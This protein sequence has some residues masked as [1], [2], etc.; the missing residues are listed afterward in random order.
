MLAYAVRVYCTF[1][2]C[3]PKV[4]VKF[5]RAKPL[6][7]SGGDDLADSSTISHAS[8][9]G[10]SYSITNTL[11]VRWVLYRKCLRATAGTKLY[12][13]KDRQ[14]NAGFSP[15]VSYRSSIFRTIL[16]WHIS[17]SVLQSVH[18][19]RSNIFHH[20]IEA[21][22]YFLRTNARFYKIRSMT[23]SNRVWKMGFFWRNRRLIKK[24]VRDRP[25]ANTDY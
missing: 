15:K 6:S 5:A 17:L 24:T 7:P 13:S 16:M 12:C 22:F 9:T 20:L 25:T 11:S 14:R 3:L 21:S 8:D 4:K 18:M 19:R 23:P 1:I 10:G 2:A